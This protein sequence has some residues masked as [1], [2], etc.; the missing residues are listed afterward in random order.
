MLQKWLHRPRPNNLK[1][2]SGI[3]ISLGKRASNSAFYAHV[4]EKIVQSGF[5]KV[6][7]NGFITPNSTHDNSEESKAVG[8][9]L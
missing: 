3:Y 9:A 1:S 7:E 4:E 5:L 2:T 6:E 8:G